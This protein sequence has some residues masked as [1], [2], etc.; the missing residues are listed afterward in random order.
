MKYYH[1]GV[2]IPVRWGSNGLSY[3]QKGFANFR[4]HK[5]AYAYS[6]GFGEHLSAGLKLIYQR[7]A[8]SGDIPASDFISFD[9]GISSE[10]NKKLILAVLLRN[11]ANIFYSYANSPPEPSEIN[12]AVSFSASEDLILYVSIIKTLNIRTTVN[13]G[14]EYIIKEKIRLRIGCIP[15]PFVLAFGIGINYGHYTIDMASSYHH[16]L[17]FTPC[18][19]VINRFGK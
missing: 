11:P 7:L 10:V 14:I 8:Y 2:V 5:M 1:L 12:L 13:A 18:I 6:R 4:T 9:I 15:S 3:A 16:I 17:G 19:S